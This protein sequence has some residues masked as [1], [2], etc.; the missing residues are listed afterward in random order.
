[1]PGGNGRSLL[2]RA[3][4]GLL[5]AADG[6][7]SF[8]LVTALGIPRLAIVSNVGIGGIDSFGPF[9][10]PGRWLRRGGGEMRFRGLDL[11]L[12]VT[13]DRLLTERNV[14][15]AAERLCLSQSA[16]SGA[17]IRLREYFA[18]DLLVQVGRRMTLTPRAEEL[19]VAVRNV[20]LQVEGTIIERPTLDVAAVRRTVRV[21]TS[22]YVGVAYLDGVIRALQQ[23]APGIS[24]TLVAPH[25]D[26][27]AQL[28]RGLIDFAA[29]PERLLTGPHPSRTIFVDDHS[30]IVDA[31][32]RR[33]GQTLDLETFMSLRQVT[34]QLADGPPN[35]ESAI[36]D[37]HG[38]RREMDVIV[39][40]FVSVPFMVFGTE[41]AAVVHS[42]L[43]AIFCRMMP[44]RLF[45]APMPLPP[46]RIGLQ[47][48]ELCDS[49]PALGFVRSRL[50]ALA[51]NL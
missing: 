5:P 7:A 38:N 2:G 11:N 4:V 36:S 26:A 33:V 25:S 50:L 49:D 39:S 37:L 48:H 21:M 18:D 15:R 6:F 40:N 20:L 23:E 29:M 10:R 27:S 51:A 42:R 8:V 14:S 35:Y 32:N 1:M 22:D 47:W 17:L 12:L 24:F 31:D 30:V 9:I 13:L 43:G 28:A 19:A 41:R 16:T 3:A 44:L 34:V 46:L 45:P